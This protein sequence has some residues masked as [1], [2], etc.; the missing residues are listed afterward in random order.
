MAIFFYNSLTR[1]KEEFNPI[2]DNEVKM[3]TC[4]P[5]VYNYPHI[6][7]L[8][9]FIFEDLLHRWLE[10]RGFKVIQV[11]NL[12]DVDDKTI[13]NSQANKMSLKEYT[14]I[15]KKAFFEDIET[16]N[17]KKATYYPAAT[18]YIEEMIEMIKVLLDKGYAYETNDGIYFKISS[19]P[20]Y[21]KLAHLEKDELKAGASGRVSL[22]EYEKENVSDFALWKKWTPEDG[23]VKWESPFGPGR[24]G[25]HIECSVMS[26]K[27]LGETFDIHCG[28]IDNLFPHHENEIAQ[29]EAYSG[30]KFVNYWL[31]SVHLIVNG[32]KMS[33]S[34]GNFFTLRDLLAKGYSARSIRYA[35]LTTH[36]RKPLNF[37]FDLLIQANSSL[38]RIDDFIFALK[39]INKEGQFDEFL[40]SVLD[41][42]IKKFEEAMDDDLNISEAIAS[43]FELINIYYENFDNITKELANKVIEI[44]KRIDNVLGFIFSNE[45]KD[46]LTEEEKTLIEERTKAKKEKN[47]AK[48]DEIRN[49]LLS[50]GIELRDTKEGVIWKRIK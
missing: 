26:M 43:I 46:E 30:K 21:G 10:Y 12:T 17:I 22:D 6:G 38:K 41:N 14:D 19:F 45:Q 24:P 37:T 35:L 11:M 40:K 47:F 7:N 39:N 16:L 42:Q 20:E 33:K 5:T 15:Y 9:T 27:L 48:A 32:E 18:E 3:Y 44:F 34:K 31:H 23:E 50:K 28:G 36:Y 2:K 49:I 4:G 8:R 13:K 25:W 29:S 1:K